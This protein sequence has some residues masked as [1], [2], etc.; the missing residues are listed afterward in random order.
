MFHTTAKT[1]KH[2]DTD[3]TQIHM[4]ENLD[5]IA[6][7]ADEFGLIHLIN[8]VKFLEKKSLIENKKGLCTDLP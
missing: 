8:E 5:K 1:Y 3:N 2:T 6:S 7:K 4:Q